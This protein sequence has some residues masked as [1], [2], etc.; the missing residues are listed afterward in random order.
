MLPRV[1]VVHE[2]VSTDVE[3]AVAEQAVAD[4]TQRGYPARLTQ[5][6]VFA[7]YSS[8]S[9]YVAFPL[10]SIPSEYRCTHLPASRWCSTHSRPIAPPAHPHLAASSPSHMRRE[11]DTQWQSA[12]PLRRLC[13]CA[14]VTRRIHISILH[15]PLRQLHYTTARSLC[16]QLAVGLRPAVRAAGRP[17]EPVG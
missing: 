7:C 14:R 5:T 9:S 2:V 11:P 17:R 4:H 1:V 3:Q 15:T 12:A 16:L 10:H 6:Y 8:S 13:A